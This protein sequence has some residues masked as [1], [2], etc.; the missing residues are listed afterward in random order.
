MKKRATEH[1]KR[2]SKSRFCK[3]KKFAIK[4]PVFVDT[5]ISKRQDEISGL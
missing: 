1:S 3:K 4:V 2:V 5:E